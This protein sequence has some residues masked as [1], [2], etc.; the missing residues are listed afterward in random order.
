V[1]PRTRAFG[2]VQGGAA[3]AVGRKNAQKAQGGRD[4]GQDNGMHSENP[5]ILS[6]ISAD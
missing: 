6:E 4:L 5:V 2:T 3:K 1:E